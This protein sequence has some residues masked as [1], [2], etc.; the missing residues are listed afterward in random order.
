MR[1]FHKNQEFIN[2]ILLFLRKKFIPNG[3]KSYWIHQ[4]I[5]LRQSDLLSCLSDFLLS[6]YMEKKSMI[7][8]FLAH[9]FAFFIEKSEF[10]LHW[11]TKEIEAWNCVNVQYHLKKKKLSEIYTQQMKFKYFR[12]FWKYYFCKLLPLFKGNVGLHISWNIFWTWSHL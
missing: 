5:L 1:F 11:V 6:L 4:A 10:P 2:P 8:L 12:N 9:K 3:L 7:H